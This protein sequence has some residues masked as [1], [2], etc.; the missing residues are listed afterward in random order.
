MC[1]ADFYETH[2][3]VSDIREFH[4]S[5][6]AKADTVKISKSTPEGI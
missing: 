5:F 6:R 4:D 2:E 1:N 3:G